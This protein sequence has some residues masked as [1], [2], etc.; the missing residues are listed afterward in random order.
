MYKLNNIDL[1]TY[2]FVPTKQNG[3]DLALSGFLDLPA[4]LG[5][6]FHDWPGQHGVE[7]YTRADEIRLG[8]RDLSLLGHIVGVDRED[9]AGKLN[10]LYNAINSW[11]ALVPLSCDWGTFQ[12]Y[13]KEP[14]IGDYL[15][16]GIMKVTIPMREP[17]PIISG[18]LPPSSDGNEFG[19]DGIKWATVGGVLVSLEGDR[20]NRTATKEINFTAYQKE[21]YSIGKT[22]ESKITLKLFIKQSTFAAFKIAITSLQVLFIQPGERNLI[23]EDDL[24]R[25]VF[26]CN[27][28]QVTDIRN[29]N[30]WYGM[31][32][33]EL[34]QSQLPQELT[35]LG[36]NQGNY[37]TDNLNNKILVQWQ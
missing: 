18:I 13:V 34:M 33:V 12:V 3:S 17:M 36:D 8:G 27:G 29:D 37:I 7:P 11:N 30:G 21:A 35:F 15:G 26:A 9:C 1:T 31:V 32:N 23:I 4:R 22:G 28:M 5:K 10:D 6:C 24:Q 16:S 25:R 20:Y 19:I 2:S 14:V